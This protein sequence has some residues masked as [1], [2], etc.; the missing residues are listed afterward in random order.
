M[1]KVAFVA[2]VAAV[3]VFSAA[4]AATF[5]FEIRGASNSRASEGRQGRTTVHLDGRP[6]SVSIADTPSAREVGLGGRE[7]LAPDEGMLFVFPKDDT[8]GFWMRGMRF[9]I[10]IIWLSGEG[11]V[12]NMKQNVSPAT[13][14]HV[15]EP[16]VPAR[17]VLELPAGY[18]ER[19][20]VRLGSRLRL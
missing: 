10:D 17:Y 7:A 18:A 1:K 9:S 3:V 8:Y 11:V 6:L 20:T 5:F 14:P 12:V 13:Y 4:F 16:S 15:F 2:V 19:Y